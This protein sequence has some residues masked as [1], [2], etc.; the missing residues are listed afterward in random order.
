MATQP[1]DF[2][3]TQKIKPDLSGAM[4]YAYFGCWLDI[5][6]SAGQFNSAPPPTGSPD[7]P[8]TSPQSIASRVMN[9][10][11]CLVAEIS[12]DSI[13]IPLGANPGDNDQ[14]AQ[15]NLVVIGGTNG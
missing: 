4:V 11:Q 14:L 15:R 12:F 6:Q 3:N 9:S 10:H 1:P 8:F 5:N 2:P 13:P 7:G